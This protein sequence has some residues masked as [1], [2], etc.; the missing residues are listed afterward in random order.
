[1]TAA[2]TLARLDLPPAA[3]LTELDAVTRSIDTIASVAYVIQD[4]A[5][6]TLTVANGG[7]LPPALRHPDGTA[8][9]LDDPH[10]IILGVTEQT[11]TETRHRFPPG[12]T[13][14][15]YTDGLVESPTVD[16][17]EG[18]R[19]LLRILTETADLPT[20]ADRLLTLLNRNDG[21]DGYDDDVTLLLAHARRGR[22][23]Q[24]ESSPCSAHRADQPTGVTWT[25]IRRRQA[26]Q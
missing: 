22:R 17:G 16:I 5:T 10:G 3:L 6:S 11:F 2:R 14:A 20:T 8:D 15:L 4:P 12:S 21:N 25:T 18:C 13:L 23:A 1:R 9:L 24:T 26:R 19:R 7:H